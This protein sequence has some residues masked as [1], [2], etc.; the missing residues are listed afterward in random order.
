MEAR[1]KRFT[2]RSSEPEIMDDLTCTGEVLFQTLR[3][4]DT[5]NKWLG[6]NSVTLEG[7]QKLLERR[8]ELNP[9]SLADLGCGGG[10][11][12]RQL[13]RLA[14]RKGKIFYLTGV[15]ANPNVVKYARRQ[16]QDLSGVNL[17]EQDVLSDEFNQQ[18]FDIVIATLFLHHFSLE[19]LVLIVSRLKTQVRIGF[20]INDIHRHWLA[21]YSIRFLTKYFSRSSMVRYDAPLSVLRAFSKKELINIMERAGVAEYTIRWRWAFRWQVIAYV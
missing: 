9:V 11:M 3:E 20:V 18:K 7:V 8:P 16:L 2:N 14:E 12:L 1:A 5:I 13:Q 21:F 10:G 4:L 6:G 17:A 15:D 19:Q